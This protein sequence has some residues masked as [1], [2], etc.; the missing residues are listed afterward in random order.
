MKVLIFHGY[1]LHGTGSNIYNASLARA[2]AGLGQ[3]GLR[4]QALQLANQ[5]ND[6]QRYML[7]SEYYEVAGEDAKGWTV[8]QAMHK[9]RG[10]KGTNV[11]VGIK[12]RG[13][14]QL[15]PIQLT[16]DEVTIPTVRCHRPNS[17]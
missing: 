1:L 10:P 3:A 15:I 16:R 8:D 11:E 9:L 6:K 13:Y 17:A 12:R 4:S 5:A 2:L 7:A 14:E